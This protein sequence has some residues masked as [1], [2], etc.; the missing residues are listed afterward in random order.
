[1]NKLNELFTAGPFEAVVIS[2]PDATMI[3]DVNG[4]DAG[5]TL[6]GDYAIDPV[7][8]DIFTTSATHNNKA[9]LKSVAT[10][11]QAGEYFTFDIRGEGQIG[12]GLIHTQ[13][14]YDA[15]PLQRQ[16]HVR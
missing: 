4:V 5:Y 7:G 8:N 13:D 16:R 1:M 15:R 6:E 2:D 10:I 3:A 12:F 11:D 9:G 14:S